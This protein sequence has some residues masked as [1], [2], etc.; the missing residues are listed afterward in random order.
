MAQTA[1]LAAGGLDKGRCQFAMAPPASTALAPASARISR[2]SVRRVA[3]IQGHV[4]Q[5]RLLGA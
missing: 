4:G 5:A 2:C 3:G 1:A